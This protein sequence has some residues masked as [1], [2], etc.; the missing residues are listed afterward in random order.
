MCKAIDYRT[1][2]V[3]IKNIL[4]INE[5]CTKCVKSNFHKFFFF[6][7]SNHNRIARSYFFSSLWRDRIKFLI[8]FQKG[9][10]LIII[11]ENWAL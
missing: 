3:Y 11:P 10:V 1:N 4:C 2:K 6:M 7:E 9:N 5:Y 8:E